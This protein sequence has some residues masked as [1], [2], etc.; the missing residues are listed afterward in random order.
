MPEPAAIATYVLA[1]GRVE[2]GGEPAGGRH[3]LELVADPERVDDALAERSA[4]EPLHAD[5][6]HARR[7]RGADRVAAAYVVA[8]A[9][10][11][12]LAVREGVV[13]AQV[14]G[15]VERDRDRVVGQLV[16]RRDAQRVEHRVLGH[17]V[18]AAFR[19][20]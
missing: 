10:V 13:V 16:D 9:D 8:A 15:D 1:G 20:S 19:G 12:V 7:G 2:L 3:H 6:Q 5:P 17:G 11:E 4:R 18:G 14:V